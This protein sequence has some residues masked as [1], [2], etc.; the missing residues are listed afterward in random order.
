[1]TIEPILAADIV[2]NRQ[3]DNS[4]LRSRLSGRVPEPRSVVAELRTAMLERDALG[5]LDAPSTGRKHAR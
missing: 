5:E 2:G 1:M 3:G 4:G